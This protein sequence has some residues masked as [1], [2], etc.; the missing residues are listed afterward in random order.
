ME[1]ID[2]YPLSPKISHSFLFKDQYLFIFIIYEF[3]SIIP[4]A[5]GLWWTMLESV[6]I[7]AT[8]KC[9]QNKT[10][11]IVWRWT[12]MEVSK[13]QRPS[14]R[15]SD[16]REGEWCA[17]PAWWVDTQHVLHRMLCQSLDLKLIVMFSGLHWNIHRLHMYVITSSCPAACLQ[18]KRCWFFYTEQY[19]EPTWKLKKWKVVFCMLEGTKT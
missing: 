9:A 13:S 18:S 11:W 2:R 16:W 1:G 5:Y 17:S 6:G 15:W 8:L 19:G 14:S 4:Q 10:L 12:C 3:V 7:P